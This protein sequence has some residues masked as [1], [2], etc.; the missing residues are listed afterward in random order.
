MIEINSLTK[1]SD[2]VIAYNYADSLRID[3]DYKRTILERRL[4]NA[5]LNE[6]ELA[7]DIRKLDAKLTSF[8]TV[9]ATLQEGPESQAV[10]ELIAKTQSE[11][12]AAIADQNNSGVQGDISRQLEHLLLNNKVNYIDEYESALTALRETLP[13]E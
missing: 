10:D 12:D 3:L 11:L 7:D 9:R 8:K 13:S 6:Q 4:D 2:V 1:V 5:I